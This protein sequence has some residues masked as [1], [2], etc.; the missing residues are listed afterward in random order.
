ME[1]VNSI[2]RL[3]VVGATKEEA[4]AKA[5]FFIQK[6]ATQ[7]FKNW[8]EKQTGAITDAAVKQF[9]I[10]YVAKNS[11]NA[12]GVGFSIT[13]QSAVADTRERPYAIEDLKNEKGARRYK[14]VYSWIDDETEKVVAEVDTTKADA[15]NA[16]KAL[17]TE[18][19]YKG[20]ATLVQRKKCV[21]GQAVVAKVKYTPSKS[22]RNGV[23]T[24]FGIPAND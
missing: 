4:L 7:A 6:D 5:P 15:K 2:K 21:E 24:V 11:K 1:K 23:Y 16:I 22:S 17:Y 14:T 18:K 19:G 3:E 12:P 20:N 8:K 9:M 10:D 13:E